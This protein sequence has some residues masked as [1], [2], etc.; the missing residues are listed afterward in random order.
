MIAVSVSDRL[1]FVDCGANFGKTHCP[2][3]GA[4][5]EL[6]AWQAWMD[7]DFQGKDKG[8]VLSKRVLQ[9]CGASASLH[10]LK[11][12][13]P[14]GFARFKICAENPNIG[15]LSQEHCRRF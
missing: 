15:K 2:A 12:E 14:Q 11:Y 10:D 6:R 3:C 9:C 4:L 5:I 1:G 8:F 7:H 13:W